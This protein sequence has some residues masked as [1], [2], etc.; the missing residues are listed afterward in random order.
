MNETE[1]F[2]PVSDYLC[3]PFGARPS[4]T[5]LAIEEWWG[6]DQQTISIAERFAALC[7]LAFPQDLY[8]GEFAALGDSDTA[9]ALREKD[10][11]GAPADLEPVFDDLKIH[12][13]WDAWK[14]TAGFFPRHMPCDP[15]KRA[16]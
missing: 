11:Q 1:Q 5:F 8:H 14:K 4:P 6:L 7:Y 10:G 15:S 16:G 9:S 13:A 3:R 2:G 12:S